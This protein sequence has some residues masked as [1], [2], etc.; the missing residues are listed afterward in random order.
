MTKSQKKALEYLA[1]KYGTLEL[2]N[3]KDGIIIVRHDK[4]IESVGVRGGITTHLLIFNNK[5]YL[6]GCWSYK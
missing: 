1:R 4:G 3:S 6:N 5:F 2:F